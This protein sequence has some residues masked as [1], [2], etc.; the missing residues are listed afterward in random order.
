MEKS[1]SQDS[2]GDGM[3]NRW[4]SSAGIVLLPAP[5]CILLVGIV[6]ILVGAQGIYTAVTNR[7]PARMTLEQ[8]IASGNQGSWLELDG[9]ELV[10]AAGAFQKNS[11]TAPDK[12]WIPVR[13]PGHFDDP[14]HVVLETTDRPL[15]LLVA[16]LKS[17]GP[18]E[19][20]EKLVAARPDSYFQK[21][22]IRG[23]VQRG[24]DLNDKEH[25][26]LLAVNPNLAGD[27][28]IIADG[29]EPR[30]WKSVLMFGGGVILIGLLVRTWLIR[31]RSAAIPVA[32]RIE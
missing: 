7:Q 27:F 22:N 19:A 8:L 21:R 4:R 1:L 31:R 6:L 12:V 30:P 24:M 23:L 16:D 28:L 17:V 11:A 10:V 26:A 5:G 9:C 25:K 14:V 13:I 3:I 20:S 29:E 32:Q 18:G 15:C 2:G